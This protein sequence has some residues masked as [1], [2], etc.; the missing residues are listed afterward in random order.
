MGVN[1]K[2][3]FT[4]TRQGMTPYQ[5]SRVLY[6]FHLY[7]LT[8]FHHGDCVGADAEAHVIAEGIIGCE[9][10]V[11]HPPKISD[12]RA[13]CDAAKI[14]P[15]KDYTKRNR[16]IVDSV[17]IMIATPK[18]RK[19]QQ[20]GLGTWSTIRYSENCMTGGYL[21]RLHIIFPESER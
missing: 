10:I 4:G 8:E 20:R 21:K 11:I 6:L 13:F 16:D 9:R 17:D 5:K 1:M 18:S 7:G 3:G 19:E 12:L 15:T 2:I 14:L